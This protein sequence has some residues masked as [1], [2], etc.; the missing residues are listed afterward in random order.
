MSLDHTRT[1]P[2][3]N[4]LAQR[5]SSGHAAVMVGSGFSKNAIPR[6]TSDSSLPDWSELGDILY[7]KLH[8]KPPANDAKYIDILKLADELQAALGRPA[9]HQILR[10]AIPDSDFEPSPLH[11]ML[12]SLEWTDVFTTNYDTLLERALEDSPNRRYDVVL[13]PNELVYSVRPRIVKLHGSFSSPSRYVITD[14]DYRNYPKEFAPFVN[15][16]RQSLIESTLCLI[17][18]SGD[19]P[20]FLQWIRWI[21]DNLG[22]QTSPKIYLVSLSALSDAQKGL[23]H[24]HNISLVDISGYI[25]PAAT[26][27]TRLQAFLQY[28]LFRQAEDDRLHWP[29]VDGDLLEPKHDVDNH[30]QLSRL[31]DSWKTTRLSFPGWVVVPEDRR[32]QLWLYTHRWIP[33]I[34]DACDPADPT[35][36]E[37]VYEM[38]WRMNKCLCPLLDNQ[39]ATIE[40]VLDGH[41][42]RLE[43]DSAPDSES[44]SHSSSASHRGPSPDHLRHHLL[45]SLL[46]YY[47]LEGDQTRWSACHRELQLDINQL[48]PE[49]RAD[50]HYQ[51]SLQSL[52]GL[53]LRDL[54]DTLARWPSNDALP[55][56]EA[57][58]AGLLAESGQPDD[59]MRVIEQSLKTIRSQ[60][61]LRPIAADYALVSQESYV[62]LLLR[63]FKSAAE[64]RRGEFH[65]AHQTDTQFADRWNVLK[66]YKCDPW[67]EISVL[68]QSLDKPY[69]KRSRTV[70][71]KL[72]DIGAKK[73]TAH[74]GW[75]DSDGREALV[76]YQFLLLHEDA[77]IPFRIPGRQH[78][79][80][81]RYGCTSSDF[82][83]LPPLGSYNLGSNC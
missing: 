48:S 40:S 63:Y 5:L 25:D 4:E 32:R 13:A 82:R 44:S 17:G 50:Y 10:D 47:R 30:Q 53:N 79:D 1:H 24:Q 66:R 58:R 60:L 39:A 23:L 6:T 22:I 67:N 56:W 31:I 14:D 18:F 74:F 11:S 49:H 46:R 54:Q 38:S 37:V 61:N 35:S 83:S 78:L 62:M 77:G 36:L 12:L 2:F 73:A 76:G 59:A 3:L 20:N 72:F 57:R 81:A 42:P 70:E 8:G 45:L 68:E 80:N 16:V 33:L 64:F 7:E 51:Q 27:Y 15:T 71:T 29:S 19:D 28:L 43:L 34:C 69:V 55:L 52:F 9:L 75:I 21:H 26:H 41:P 65:A